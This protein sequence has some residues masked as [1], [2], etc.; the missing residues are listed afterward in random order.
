EIGKMIPEIAD[1]EERGH[2]LKSLMNAAE[3]KS[4]GWKN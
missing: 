2:P 3:R 4:G 1:V